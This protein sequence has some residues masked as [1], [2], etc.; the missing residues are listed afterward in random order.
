MYHP[1]IVVHKFW[2]ILIGPVYTGN[3]G[4]YHQI[5]NFYHPPVITIKK[6]YVYLPLP[7]KWVVKM[8]WFF[9]H[10]HGFREK[11][12]FIPIEP[13]QSD[14]FCDKPSAFRGRPTCRTS[15]SPPPWWESFKAK[16]LP[17]DFTKSWQLGDRCLVKFT[18]GV[19]EVN[20][21]DEADPIEDGATD[22]IHM[23]KAYINKA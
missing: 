9:P 11:N 13:I 2:P 1:F 21:H 5:M 16:P 15:T 22:S 10:R 18:M 6:W 3:H 7:G 19:F 23:F 20:G 4:F 12:C 17:V 14:V 8:A